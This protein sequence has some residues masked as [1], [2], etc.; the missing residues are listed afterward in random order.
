MSGGEI[1]AWGI[2]GIL[3]VIRLGKGAAGEG[4]EGRLLGEKRFGKLS[5]ELVLWM[6]KRND[7]RGREM[8]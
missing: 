8:V 6:V 5:G 2:C 3:W 1:Y 7:R 4:R